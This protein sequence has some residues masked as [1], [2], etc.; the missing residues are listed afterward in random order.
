MDIRL[1][2]ISLLKRAL[3]GDEIKEG[4]LFAVAPDPVTSDKLEQA[5]WQRLSQWA[6]DDGVRAK[7]KALAETQRLQV[8]EALADLEALEAGYSPSEIAWGEHR[9]TEFPL[10]GCLV[11]VVALA[12]LLYAI[13]A[14]GLFPH[15][16]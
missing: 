12:A 16:N 4:D 3:A 8:V 2:L 14:L 10:I 6:G 1:A 5:A 13:F 9:G 7:D 11:A 15:F